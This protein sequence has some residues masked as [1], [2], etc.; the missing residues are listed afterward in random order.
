[1]QGCKGETTDDAE[2]TFEAM[3]GKTFQKLNLSS[4]A[5]VTIV[6]PFGAMAK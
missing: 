2:S 1:M 5:P 6:S 4:P 3:L